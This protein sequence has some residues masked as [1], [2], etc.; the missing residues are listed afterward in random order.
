ML[1]LV[2]QVQRTLTP[3]HGSS[4]NISALLHFRMYTCAVHIHVL[5]AV[6]MLYFDAKYYDRNVHVASGITTLS[7]KMLQHFD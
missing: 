5:L 7:I 2:T 4:I 6:F 1:V 3:H